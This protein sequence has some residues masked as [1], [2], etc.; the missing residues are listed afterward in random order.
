MTRIRVVRPRS[1]ERIVGPAVTRRRDEDG[2]TVWEV[3]PHDDDRGAMHVV[4]TVRTGRMLPAVMAANLVASVV[5]TSSDNNAARSLNAN[6]L[7]HDSSPLWCGEC[8]SSVG[9]PS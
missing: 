2:R 4:A 9:Q 6:R 7:C 5:P 8:C 1:A 3:R